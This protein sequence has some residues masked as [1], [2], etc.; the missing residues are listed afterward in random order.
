MGVWGKRVYM[1][2]L[3]CRTMGVTSPP[4]TLGISST[5]LTAE[6]PPDKRTSACVCALF[7]TCVTN[8]ATQ[9][10]TAPGGERQGGWMEDN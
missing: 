8:K 6:H 5:G 9:M 3:I 7:N 2:E 4:H 1:H 10:S